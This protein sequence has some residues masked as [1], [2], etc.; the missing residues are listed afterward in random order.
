MTAENQQQVRLTQAYHLATTAQNFQLG[1]NVLASLSHL[2]VQMDDARTAERLAL[3]GI[4]QVTGS[5]AHAPHLVARLHTMEGRALAMQ[6]KEREARRALDAGESALDS[7]GRG[8]RDS[9]LSGF[10]R[11]SFAGEV[12][13]CTYDLQRYEDA[14]Q[15][16]AEVIALRSAS[17]RVRSRIL[18]SL[19]LANALAA[20]GD[21]AGAAR[22]GI[23][24]ITAAP[25][26]GSARAHSGLAQLRQR[27]SEQS[28][29]PEV[30]EMNDRLAASAA[31]AQIP[32]AQAEWSV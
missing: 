26:L 15:S 28:A 4:S 5:Q 10:D 3:K 24:I 23:E 12:A 1:S 6:G 7:V 14:T 2:A 17:D 32:E 22:V 21:H 11:A 29:L 16:A 19:T 30:S 20:L 9:W 8:T 13:L 27:L 18:A 25:G 31:S